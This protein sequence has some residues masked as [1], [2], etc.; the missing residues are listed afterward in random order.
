MNCYLGSSRIPVYC[1]RWRSNALWGARCNDED[2]KD[3]EFTDKVKTILS[4]EKEHLQ[5]CIQLARQ[6]IK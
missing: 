3:T 5:Q 2:I 6:N 1:R 4:E